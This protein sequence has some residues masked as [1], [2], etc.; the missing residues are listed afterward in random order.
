MLGLW[1]CFALDSNITVYVV[2]TTM[3]D[4]YGGGAVFSGWRSMEEWLR[5]GGRTGWERKEDMRESSAW[6]DREEGME[7][8]DE[9]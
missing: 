9:V 4:G 1:V 5:M 2:I 8:R 6:W 3:Y 7:E